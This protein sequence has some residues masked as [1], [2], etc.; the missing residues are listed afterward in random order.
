MEKINL[1][2]IIEDCNKNNIE[3]KMLRG[4]GV[5]VDSD[6]EFIFIKKHC[7]Y[8]PQDALDLLGIKKLNYESGYDVNISFEPVH[9]GYYVTWFDLVSRKYN[10]VPIINNKIDYPNTVTLISY[11][12]DYLLIVNYWYDI[13]KNVI[14]NQNKPACWNKSRI[15]FEEWVKY[16]AHNYNCYFG[17][18]DGQF[19]Y[20]QINELKKYNPKVIDLRYRGYKGPDDFYKVIRKDFKPILTPEESMKKRLNINDSAS[21]Y[22]GPMGR[23]TTEDA[24]NFYTPYVNCQND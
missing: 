15:D 16:N 7:K 22:Y 6:H 9:L 23:F 18:I 8:V 4:F 3:S 11:K 1:E 21:C 19:R 13:I 20:W 2:E 12:Y 17:I 10:W 24:N 5:D 14:C